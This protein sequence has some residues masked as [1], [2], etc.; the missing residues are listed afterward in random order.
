MMNNN[1]FNKNNKFN[2]NNNFN[3][4]NNNDEALKDGKKLFMG[5][6]L[7]TDSSLLVPKLCSIIEMLQKDKETSDL[8][9]KEL[10]SLVKS[11]QSQIEWQKSQI[12]LQKSQI[13]TL[14][15]KIKSLESQLK[16]D[17]HNSSKPPSS[18]GFRKT[19]SLRIKSDKKAGGQKGHKGH[20]LKIVEKPDKV[21]VYPVIK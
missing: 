4:N 16:M 6:S 8:R 1:H 13:E 19:K 10:E 2:R 5:L 20:A 9:I 7:D 11:Q 21:I 14:K 15:L 3:E 12:E 17:S 18:D